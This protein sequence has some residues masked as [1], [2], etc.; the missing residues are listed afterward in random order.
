MNKIAVKK[1]CAV[2]EMWS[3]KFDT[4]E[5]AFELDLAEALVAKWV[6]NYRDIARGE[7]A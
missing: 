4:Y 3:R 6:A 2:I 1:Y 7:A 5:I